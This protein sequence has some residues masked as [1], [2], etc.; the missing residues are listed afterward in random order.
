MPTIL[1][2]IVTAIY[3]WVAAGFLLNGQWPLGVMYAGYAFANI[4]AIMMVDK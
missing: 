4:G 3:A 2:L 1:L